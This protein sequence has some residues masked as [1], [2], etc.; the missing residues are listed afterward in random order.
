MGTEKHST[1]ERGFFPSTHWSIVVDAGYD[2]SIVRRQALERFL[3]QYTEALKAHLI[4]R[5]RV[6]PHQAEDL[7]QGFLLSRVL[8]ADLI[9]KADRRRGR[10]RSYLLTSLDRY[11]ANEHRGARAQKRGGGQRVDLDEAA[12]AV[13]GDPSP[14]RNFEL[15][16]AQQVLRE[17]VKR[18]RDHCDRTGRP[19]LW[20]IFEARVLAPTLEAAEPVPYEQLIIR[21]SLHSADQA[22]NLLATAKRTFTRAMRSVIA[23]YET[24]ESAIDAEIDELRAALARG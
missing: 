9:R 17:A 1:S 14:A 5:K 12:D 7:I 3:A 13:D 21:Y 8:E 10:F 6:D 4:W 20:G 23:E 24:E 11:M 18:M 22:A 16:W 15:A 2:Q 19:E